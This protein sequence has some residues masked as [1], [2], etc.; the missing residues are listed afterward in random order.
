[1]YVDS[2][3]VMANMSG[4]EFE[5]SGLKVAGFK[6]RAI[7]V[8]GPFTSQIPPLTG[9]MRPAWFLLGN[10]STRATTWFTQKATFCVEVLPQ[11]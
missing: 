7:E 3:L 1:M 11:A 10:A 8:N 4:S 2:G 6:E 9:N 5:P